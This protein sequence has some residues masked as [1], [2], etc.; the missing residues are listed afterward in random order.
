MRCPFRNDSSGKCFEQ[1]CMLW[2]DDSCAIKNISIGIWS[3]SQMLYES[4]KD[5]E[6]EEQPIELTEEY[7][8]TSGQDR[9]SY[10]DTQDRKN[11]IPDE[12]WGYSKEPDKKKGVTK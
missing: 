11:Y 5:A 7:D 4:S 12:D 8:G 6:E 9:K 10:T 2:E 3:I 1:Y